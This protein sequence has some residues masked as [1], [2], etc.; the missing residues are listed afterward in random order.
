MAVHDYKEIIGNTT[1]NAAPLG[2]DAGVDVAIRSCHA[3]HNLVSVKMK[4]YAP[5][6][7]PSIACFYTTALVGKHP[8]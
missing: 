1:E 4:Q 5:N 3:I 7:Q 6:A 2:R 8:L